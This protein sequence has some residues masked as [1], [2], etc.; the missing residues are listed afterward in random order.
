MPTSSLRS[1][2]VRAVAIG[3]VVLGLGAMATLAAWTDQEWATSPFSSGHFN[4]EG[5]TD[6]NDF[7]DNASL[8][9][10]AGL[11]FST[12]AD[13]LAPGQSV[14]S[15]FDIRLGEG[16]TTG[17]TIA[18][19]ASGDGDNLTYGIQKLAAG[20][21]C[22]A[23]A[24]GTTVVPAGATLDSAARATSFTL[25]QPAGDE[26]GEAAHLCITVT[27]GSELEQGKTGTGVWTFTATS[28]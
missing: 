1:R 11:T 27:A 24:T 13:N 26:A 4:L 5:S 22:T 10:A 12:G 8:D 2:R 3:G 21:E 16:T 18:T 17:A 7:T 15:A 25:A 23:S 6:G 19:K 28:N 9:D 20:A 14:A